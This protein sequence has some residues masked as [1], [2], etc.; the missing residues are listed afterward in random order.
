MQS[1]QKSFAKH[2]AKPQALQ[3]LSSE[4]AQVRYQNLL[5]D[6]KLDGKSI[7]DIGCGFGDIIPHIQAK[8]KKFRYLGID[9]VPEFIKVAQNRY[10]NCQFQQG[11]YTKI[12]SPH[13]IILCSGVLNNKVTG[14]QYQYRQN[15]INIMFDHAQEALA[16]NMAGSHPQPQNRDKW[17]V[18]YVDSQ[19]I[20]KYCQNLASKVILRQDYR[21]R[22]FTIIMFK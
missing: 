11:D 20:L 8:A 15:A 12:I 5:A 1:Y 4:A 7:L 6:L 9:I 19:K 3:W 22:D 21:P 18:Y 2:G 14:N 16:F 10:P 13:D 17:K